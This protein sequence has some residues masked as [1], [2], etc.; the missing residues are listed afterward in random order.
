[1]SV[2]SNAGQDLVGGLDPN[3][4][5]GI[6]V[7]D[8]DKFADR[9]FQ[10]LHAAK[11]ATSNWFVGQFRKPAFDQVDPGTVGGREVNVEAWALGKPLANHRRFVSG[12][13]IGDEVHVQFGWHLRFNPVKELAKFYRTM[14]VTAPLTN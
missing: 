3:E 10:I 1:M 2:A 6:F 4:G 14:T 9:G 8:F 5:S 7:V 12:V 13:V 11:H